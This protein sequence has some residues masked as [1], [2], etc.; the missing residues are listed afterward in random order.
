ML[1]IRTLYDQPAKLA[2]LCMSV[3]FALI[4]GAHG[5]ERIGGLAPCALCLDQREAHWMALFA[6]LVTLI[7]AKWTQMTR[8]II[9]VVG[10]LMAVYIFSTGLSLYHAGVE[11]HWWPGPAGCSGSQIIETPEDLLKQLEK[12]AVGPSC[13]DAAWRLFGMSMAGYNMVISFAMSVLTGKAFFALGRK[14]RHN[15]YKNTAFDH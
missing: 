13:K 6:S 2:L 1:E 8:A 4:A 15:A 7:L 9:A 11:W 10:V 5:F 12:G 14:I 3:S